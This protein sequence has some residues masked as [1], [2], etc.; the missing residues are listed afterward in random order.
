MVDRPLAICT[1]KRE[2]ERGL[3]R[4]REGMGKLERERL[5]GRK[6][7]GERE[8]YKV[9]EGQHHSLSKGG[10]DGRRYQGRK[11]GNKERKG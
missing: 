9:E 10:G 6:W 5:E 2:K 7:L 1:M 4:E 3:E 8:R 11:V